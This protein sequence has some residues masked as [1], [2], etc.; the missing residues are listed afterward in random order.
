MISQRAYQSGSGER[1]RSAVLSLRDGVGVLLLAILGA[2]ILKIFV[3]DA[4][5]VPSR[6]MEGTLLEGDYVLVNKLIYGAK[7][8]RHIPFVKSD[9]SFFQLPPL[10]SIER[11]DVVVFEFPEPGL[12]SPAFF[13]KRCAAISGDVIEVHDGLLFVDGK[14]ASRQPGA[15]G[16]QV[17]G[18]DFGPVNIPRA[19]DFLE[20]TN[21]T[22]TIWRDIIAKEGHRISTGPS[23]EIL[24]DGHPASTYRVE[25]NYLFVLGDNSRHSYDSRCWGLLPEENVVG[26]AMLVYWSMSE[27]S[28]IRWERIGTLVE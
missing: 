6:S 3:V 11:G 17:L 18:A 20:L 21:D 1:Q 23:S 19:G 14:N 12:E 2:V 25:K 8:P 9:F 13:V 26:E 4:I 28:S 16:N 22:K 27:L 15:R 5:H 10:R 24:I 7:T